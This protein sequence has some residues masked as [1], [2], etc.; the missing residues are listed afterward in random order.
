M[1]TNNRKNEVNIEKK[2]RSIAIEELHHKAIVN[3]SDLRTE[4][5][6]AKW[7]NT[8]RGVV[9][10]A[11]FVAFAIASW[12]V[13]PKPEKPSKKPKKPKEATGSDTISSRKQSSMNNV[14]VQTSSGSSTEEVNTE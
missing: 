12:E 10:V 7:D 6:Q 13:A 11:L 3:V 9:I 2:K 5:E 14:G 1:D 8:R 4:I